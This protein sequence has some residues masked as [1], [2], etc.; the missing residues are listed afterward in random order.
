MPYSVKNARLSFPE[1]RV[2]SS[3]CSFCPNSTKHKDPSYIIITDT[4]KQQI[5]TFKRL[6]MQLFLLYL[7]NNWLKQLID[8][9]NSWEIFF[10][11]IIIIAASL[12]SVSKM[13]N[14]SFKDTNHISLK[15]V[16]HHPPDII[17]TNNVRLCCFSHLFY[18]NNSAFWTLVR[19]N[20]TSE[21]INVFCFVLFFVTKVSSSLSS[22]SPNMKQPKRHFN[23][24][25]C[26]RHLR[27]RDW[28]KPAPCFSSA[29]SE[30][31]ESDSQVIKGILKALFSFFSMF[32]ITW[33]QLRLLVPTTKPDEHPS[34]PPLSKQPH[35]WDTHSVNSVVH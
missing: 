11:L 14:L 27:H 13:K 31:S 10:G 12:N 33:L 30:D 9:Q 25:L 32:L 16:Q 35:V 18:L 7:E 5:L 1:P 3:V 17:I 23:I 22:R 20:K 24:Y 19:Q 29:C 8:Y 26:A 6:N 34:R 2:T 28:T 21:G 4:E 15:N